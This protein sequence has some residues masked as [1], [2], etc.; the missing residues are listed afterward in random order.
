MQ[1]KQ[2]SGRICYKFWT[3]RNKTCNLYKSSFI[4]QT[5][6]TSKE[7][8]VFKAETV[9]LKEEWL[10][11]LGT[12]I[13]YFHAPPESKIMEG[14]LYSVSDSASVWKKYANIQEKLEVT[15]Y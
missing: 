9:R 3:A 2:S 5:L 13:V 12:I 15:A 1:Q 14:E 7:E 8:F 10:L 6:R 11:V 4:S